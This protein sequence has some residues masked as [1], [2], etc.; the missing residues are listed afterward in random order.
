MA[1]RSVSAVVELSGIPGNPGDRVFASQFYPSGVGSDGEGGWFSWLSFDPYVIGEHDGLVIAAPAG[2]YWVREID[3]SVPLTPEMFGAV[4]DGRRDCYAAFRSLIRA[5]NAQGGGQIV[6]RPQA[7][8]RLDR[9]TSARNREALPA[10][11]RV[12][13]LVIEGHGATV[14]SS[15]RFVRSIERVTQNGSAG[16]LGISETVSVSAHVFVQSSHL[17]IR[18]VVVDGEVHLARREKRTIR[19]SVVQVG[20]AGPHAFA[21][22]GCAD[23]LIENVS[24]RR[25]FADGF[26]IG[27][28]VEGPSATACRRVRMVN[29]VSRENARQGLSVIHVQGFWAEGCVFE[30][31]GR[32]SGDYGLHAPS[33]GIDIEPDYDLHEGNIRVDVKTDEI[34]FR[35]CVVSD[36][37]GSQILAIQPERVG[38]VE[39]ARCRLDHG[40]SESPYAIILG[41]SNSV[42]SDSN[43]NLRNGILYAGWQSY[44]NQNIELIN[45]DIYGNGATLLMMGFATN[46]TL[47]DGCRINANHESAEEPDH[48]FMRVDDD[49][50]VMKNSRIYVSSEAYVRQGGMDLR[51]LFYTGRYEGN[52]YATTGRALRGDQHFAVYYGPAARAVNELFETPYIRPGIN[53]SS[54]RRVFS[55]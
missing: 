23:V 14:V 46:R 16:L 54:P 13:N 8:Y 51:F 5:A 34:V 53:T 7:V 29:C 32:A 9:Y 49:K 6:Y 22:Y 30:R 18:D 48:Y 45:C 31:S 20:E 47:I 4:G 2:G 21:L 11:T 50:F 15:G 17:T 36:N 26:Y 27:A 38:R 44:A 52:R 24:S 19:G 28:H 1:T 40:I 25:W 3:G 43:I 37:Y 55:Q 41:T 33:A 42:V 12:R 35:D 39:L 10:Y